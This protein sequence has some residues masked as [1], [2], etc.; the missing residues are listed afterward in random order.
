MTDQPPIPP[1]ADLV[2][3]DPFAAAAPDDLLE[4]VITMHARTGASTCFCGPI[5]IG[6]SHAAHVAAAIRQEGL[7]R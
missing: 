7:A 3:R 4:L 2:A 1:I 5:R 6:H